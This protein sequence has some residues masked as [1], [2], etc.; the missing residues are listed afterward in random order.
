MS[1]R[2]AEGEDS[3]PK[4]FCVDILEVFLSILQHLRD[5]IGVI[6]DRNAL[7]LTAKCFNK[8]L[9]FPTLTRVQKQT[10][11]RLFNLNYTAMWDGG[12]K[13]KSIPYIYCGSG[14]GKTQSML[15]FAIHQVKM[16][17]SVTILS[18]STMTAEYCK[19]RITQLWKWGF[20][21]HVPN[22]EPGCISFGRYLENRVIEA[23]FNADVIL[24]GD[25]PVGDN[26][27]WPRADNFRTLPSALQVHLN[28]NPKMQPTIV[29]FGM[30]YPA[31]THSSTVIIRQ[32]KQLP[33][34]K[35][36]LHFIYT[37][38][39]IYCNGENEKQCHFTN[40]STAF[41]ESTTFSFILDCYKKYKK[42]ALLLCIGKEHSRREIVKRACIRNNIVY[43]CLLNQNQ[44]PHEYLDEF[45][46]KE[47]GLI[48][49]FNPSELRGLNIL[50]DCALMIETFPLGRHNIISNAFPRS[51]FKL[52]NNGA[53]WPLQ[54]NN[55]THFRKGGAICDFIQRICR[56]ERRNPVELFVISPSRH[57][58]GTY[59]DAYTAVVFNRPYTRVVHEV[60]LEVQNVLLD[61]TVSRKEQEEQRAESC[62]KEIKRDYQRGSQIMTVPS[63]L[64]QQFN[65]SVE[66]HER[67]KEI[68]HAS[69]K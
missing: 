39:C 29:R 44:A 54:Y 57:R 8:P 5:Y 3:K 20:A 55:N 42:I 13:V 35:L 59:A 60:G 40:E 10:L 1:K 27:D 26:G 24:I 46:K 62:R 58:I 16:G 19:I 66:R 53:L 43:F 9:E 2:S 15:I 6:H 22:I 25:W 49:V 45:N 48:L 7:R 67:F 14:L 11:Q 4:R 61:L 17:K 41:E 65:F 56:P 63:H 12:L 51:I 33:T 37:S 68:I 18:S 32:D 50:V 38:A 23:N 34:P 30:R 31:V 52:H 64:E 36:N 21:P 69:L 47:E 28:E